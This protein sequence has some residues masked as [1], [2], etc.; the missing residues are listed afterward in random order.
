MNFQQKPTNTKKATV[1]PSN[2]S[3][4]F[5]SATPARV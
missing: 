3:V 5:M 4:M 1:W 2:V